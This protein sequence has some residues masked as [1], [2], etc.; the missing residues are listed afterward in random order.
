[1]H[2]IFTDGSCL[3]NPGPTGAGAVIFSAGMNKP[4]IKP[5]KV[6]SSN[7][8]IYNREIDA[9]PLALKHILSAQSQFS[10]NTI[11]IFS[12]SSAVINSITSFFPQEIH[13]DKIEEIIRISNSL[14]C[15]FNVT[16][17]PAHCGITQNEEADRLGKV[18]AQAAQKVV[19]EQEIS[20]ATAKTKNKTLSLKIWETR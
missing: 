14:K 8:T 3:I 20:L 19:K 17:S 4:P 16:Y 15:F 10:A 18:G 2:A 5:A 11:H 9:I 12:N 1:M 7:S 13:H 6:V